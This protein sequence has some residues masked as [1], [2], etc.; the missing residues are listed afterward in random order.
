M[1][2]DG[3]TLGTAIYN[4]LNSF[5]NKS[6]DDTGDIETARLNLCKALGDAIVNYITANAVVIPIAL[7][8]P[9]GPVTG[10][11]KIT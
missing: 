9:N 1:A 11:A 6:P 3:D 7:A 2:L 8:A 4:A 10:T 5:N